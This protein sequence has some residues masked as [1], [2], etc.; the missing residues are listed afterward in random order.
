VREL[1]PEISTRHTVIFLGDRDGE[2]LL[3]LCGCYEPDELAALSD[4]DIE[5]TFAN[6]VEQRAMEASKIRHRHPAS[7]T[8]SSAVLNVT[9]TI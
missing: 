9:S 5:D 6:E 1:K 7:T 8:V 3:N 4:E 2:C